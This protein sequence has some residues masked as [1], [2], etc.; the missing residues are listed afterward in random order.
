MRPTE[1]SVTLADLYP[2]TIE[3][4]VQVINNYCLNNGTEER[5]VLTFALCYQVSLLRGRNHSFYYRHKLVP[6]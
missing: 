2:D 4:R 5:T 6:P 3:Q 1:R